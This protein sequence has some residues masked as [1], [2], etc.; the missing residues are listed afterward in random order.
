MK[1]SKMIKLLNSMLDDYYPEYKES[2]EGVAEILLFSLED[3]GMKSPSIKTDEFT[4]HISSMYSNR[5]EE[6]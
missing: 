6:E 2:N 4:G 3:E 5:W 1:R